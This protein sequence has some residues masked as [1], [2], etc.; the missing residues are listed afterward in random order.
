MIFNVRIAA[1]LS[2]LVS[3]AAGAASLSEVRGQVLVNTGSGFQPAGAGAGVSPGTAVMVKGRGSAALSY[4]DGCVVK[5]ASGAVIT[6]S[7]M[8]PCA[9]RGA[10]AGKVIDG[11]PDDVLAQAGGGA[12]PLGTGVGVAGVVV[13]GAVAGVIA[14]GALGAGDNASGA[15]PGVQ[16]PVS[17]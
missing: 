1:A 4:D 2:L 12:G 15:V 10:S 7:K 11:V 8:S 14:G 3:S 16:R 17:P 5:V 6:V 9:S 13:G